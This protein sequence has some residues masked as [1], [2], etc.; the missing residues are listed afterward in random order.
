LHNFSLEVQIGGGLNADQIDELVFTRQS[1]ILSLD[2]KIALDVLPELHRHAMVTPSL[3]R[4][5]DCRARFR[6]SPEDG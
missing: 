4:A 1:S 5:A 2:P 3:P 6:I